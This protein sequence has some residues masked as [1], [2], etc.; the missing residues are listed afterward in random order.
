MGRWST[1]LHH[2]EINEAQHITPDQAAERKEGFV[3]SE[4]TSVPFAVDE[5]NDKESG[6]DDVI[7]ITGADAAKHLLSLRDDYDSA[8]TFRSIVL[9]TVLAGFQATM[10]QIYVVRY[11]RR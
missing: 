6:S 9:A 2:P 4:I 3:D 5:E 11:L 1:F 8:L 10:F 7:I